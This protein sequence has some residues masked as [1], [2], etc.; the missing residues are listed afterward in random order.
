MKVNYDGVFRDVIWPR[1]Q[2][3]A[4]DQ[5]NGAEFPKRQGQLESSAPN[6]HALHDTFKYKQSTGP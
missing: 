1:W 6:A 4:M 3:L 5:Q 2:R